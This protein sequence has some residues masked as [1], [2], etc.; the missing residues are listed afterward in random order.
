MTGLGRFAV[1]IV[2]AIASLTVAIA[3]VFSLVPV[4]DAQRPVTGTADFRNAPL[5]TPGEYTDRIVTGD[6]A[7]YAV[8]YANGTPYEFAVDFQGS[9]GG[10]LTLS[11]SFVAPTLTT[12]DGP[13]DV[14]AGPGVHYPA[15][16]TNVWFIKVSLETTGQVGVEHPIILRLGGVESV[17]IED[18]TVTPGCT[19][20]EELAAATAELDELRGSAEAVRASETTTRVQAE[21]DNVAS[22]RDSAE[23]LLP[24]AQSRLNQAEATMAD[25][26][27]PDAFCDPFP[28]AGTTTPLLGWVVGLAA[29][30]GGAYLFFR[31]LGASDTAEADPAE[32]PT[33][34]T[35]AKEKA[36]TKAR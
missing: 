32:T 26:C 12:V 2:R 20:D 21:I 33:A 3:V 22:F 6:S 13:A 16:T 1:H 28:D 25:L 14:V 17:G 31:K 5:L 9:G 15:G 27:N 18:C 29:L 23:A 7:W 19:L 30:G 24:A 34:K 4:A 8:M 10:G 36:K 11:A 35:K